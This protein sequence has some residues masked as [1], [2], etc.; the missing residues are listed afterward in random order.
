MTGLRNLGNTCYMNS[1]IQ[2]LNN[3]SPLVTYL[4][5]DSLKP[6]FIF[7]SGL[8]ID[9]TSESLEHL[10]YE[11]YYTMFKH[12]SPLVTY[13]VTDS[14]KQLFILFQV[15]ALTGLRNLG[16]TCYMNST[17]QCLNNTSPLVTYLVTDMYLYD[18]NR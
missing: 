14:L 13:L 3:T 17:I 1:T 11:L 9:R 16:N 10:L 4:V 7:F 5:T 2:C 8:F 18:I 12:T 15:S 6:C